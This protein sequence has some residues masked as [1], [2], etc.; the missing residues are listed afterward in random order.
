M[1]SCCFLKLPTVLSIDII[2]EWLKAGDVG[3]LD[4]ACCSK[5]DR[6]MLL[7]LFQENELVFHNVHHK[8]Y[9]RNMDARLQWIIVRKVKCSG[10]FV[11]S[12]TH[13]AVAAECAIISG[14]HLKFLEICNS[15]SSSIA[16]LLAA[17][18]LR[19]HGLESLTV[20]LENTNSVN[21]VLASNPRLRSL[22]ISSAKNLSLDLHNVHLTKLCLASCLLAQTSFLVKCAT[23]TELDLTGCTLPSETSAMDIGTY[24]TQLQ[25][26]YVSDTSID[27]DEILHIVTH[28]HALTALDVSSC[29][30]LTDTGV[31]HISLHGTQLQHLQIE[32]NDQLSNVSLGMLAL[33]STASTLTTLSIDSCSNFTANSLPLLLDKCTKLTHLST[34]ID[35]N[36]DIYL[37]KCTHLQKLDLLNL[38]LEPNVCEAIAMHCGN[39]QILSLLYC[40]Q[41][42]AENIAIIARCCLKLRTIKVTTTNRAWTMASPVAGTANESREDVVVQRFGSNNSNI[43]CRW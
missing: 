22:E 15:S 28:C 18:S 7:A 10:F 14:D 11:G 16:N 19:C 21:D 4:S 12:G 3:R 6:P 13:Q 24:C 36:A 41:I 35:E 1:E 8:K 32:Y 27:D 30:G 43:R 26:L 34:T 33:H 23:L 40:K 37:R 2:S 29:F 9:G 38:Y 39:L 17:V 5:K 25:S 20:S 31:M 42:D